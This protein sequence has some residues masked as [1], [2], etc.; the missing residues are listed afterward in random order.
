LALIQ[1]QLTFNF[2]VITAKNIFT[3]VF[4]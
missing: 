4:Y 2:A 3:K 1:W